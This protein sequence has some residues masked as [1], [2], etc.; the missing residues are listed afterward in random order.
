VLYEVRSYHIDPARWDEFVAWG[1]TLAV[2]ALVDH[3][4]FRLIGS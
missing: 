4:G 1:D 3:C 2:P